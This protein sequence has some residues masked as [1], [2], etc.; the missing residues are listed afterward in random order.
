MLLLYIYLACVDKF[1][2]TKVFLGNVDVFFKQHS[3]PLPM[4]FEITVVC[5]F[6]NREIMVCACIGKEGLLD[7]NVCGQGL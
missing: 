5:F 2:K 6:Q 7:H 1:T 4:L 3:P